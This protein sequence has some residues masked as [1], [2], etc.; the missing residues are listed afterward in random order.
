[1][2]RRC[3]GSPGRPAS[4]WI[5]PRCRYQAGQVGA[6]LA[7]ASTTIS[8]KTSDLDAL[9]GGA[10]QL[11]SS[12]AGVRDQVD[13]AGQSV[14]AMTATL[15]QVRQQL[16]TVMAS[17][18]TRPAC[19]RRRGRRSTRPMLAALNGQPAVRCRCLV[20]CRTR[21]TAAT[22]RGDD[23]ARPVRECA[24]GHRA[25]R[26]HHAAVGSQTAVAAAQQKIA[27]ME[28][29]AN[30]LADG[31]A[32]LATG[33]QTLVDQTKQMGAGMNQAAEPADVDQAG[34]VGAVDGGHVRSAATPD[35]R[36]LQERR[37]AVHLAGRPL[38]ALPRRD[39]GSTRSAPRPWTRFRRS[40]TRHVAPSRTRRCPT[41]RSRWSARRRCTAPFAATTSTTCG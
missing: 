34:R 15:N 27:Q 13:Q 1:M 38:G 26:Q 3:V 6:K 24:G 29:G 8:G 22:G 4:H 30:A 11:A 12:L 10:R 20:Q 37:E 39:A 32:Q 9:S 17:M 7:D 41:R 5:R 40:S 2:S 31:S 23:Q 28:R 25:T 36:R 33:V 21:R 19:G 14:T 18:R 35:D 16:N